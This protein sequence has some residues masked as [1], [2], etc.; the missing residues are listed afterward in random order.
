MRKRLNDEDYISTSSAT[1]VLSIDA[2]AK[3]VE[4]PKRT[5]ATIAAKVADKLAASNS[6]Q[7]IMHSVLSTFAAE[8]AN[9]AGLI[10]V[11]DDTSFNLVLKDAPKEEPAKGSVPSKGIASSAKG[12]SSLT[13]GSSSSSKVGSA[14][15]VGPVTEEEIRVVLLQKAPI[16]TSDLVANFKARLKSP[17]VYYRLP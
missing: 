13:V 8:E 14:S 7:M 9:N 11:D 6:S 5:A 15:T 10:K 16:A 17:E 12:R 1:M 4:T 3:A 2:N